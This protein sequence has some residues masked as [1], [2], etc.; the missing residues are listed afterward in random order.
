MVRKAQELGMSPPQLLFSSDTPDQTLGATYREVQHPDTG[1]GQVEAA[2][3]LVRLLV[4]LGQL[5]LL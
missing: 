5:L 4:L 2:P 1:H 3:A